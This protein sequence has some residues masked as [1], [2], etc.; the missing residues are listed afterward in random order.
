MLRCPQA[1]DSPQAQPAVLRFPRARQE[2]RLPVAEQALGRLVADLSYAEAPTIIRQGLHE[3]ADDLQIRLNLVGDGIFDAFFALRP[4]ENESDS[5]EEE[6]EG[7]KPDRAT[8]AS[9]VEPAPDAAGAPKVSASGASTR[10]SSS[11]QQS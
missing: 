11:Q 2:L 5:A 3:F 4:I 9:E 8:P 1:A 7:G 10:E 6:P